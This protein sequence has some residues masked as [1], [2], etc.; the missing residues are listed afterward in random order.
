VPL[1]ANKLTVQNTVTVYKSK[2]GLGGVKWQGSALP[3]GGRA[4]SGND[5][6]FNLQHDGPGMVLKQDSY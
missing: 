6:V 2:G 1:L 3:P 4:G 5:G